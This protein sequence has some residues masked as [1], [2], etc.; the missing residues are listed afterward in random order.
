M[1]EILEKYGFP[2]LAI[3]GLCWFIMYLMKQHKEERKEMSEMIGR[4]NE[5]SNKNIKDN[6]NVL[7]GLKALIE[8]M[9]K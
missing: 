5:E 7:S 6:T 8:T 2:G 3:G 9:K 4:Q 1:Y